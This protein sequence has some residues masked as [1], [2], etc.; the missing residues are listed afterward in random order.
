MVNE[1]IENLLGSFL[2]IMYL[3]S[4][5]FQYYDH[6]VVSE[7]NWSLEEWSRVSEEDYGS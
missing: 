2:H 5:Q 3:H 6:V 1:H 7:W 4:T